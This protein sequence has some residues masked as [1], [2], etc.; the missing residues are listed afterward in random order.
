MVGADAAYPLM[1]G[2]ARLRLRNGVARGDRVS[3]A[4]ERYVSGAQ[5]G[6]VRPTAIGTFEIGLGFES[7]GRRRVDVGLGRYF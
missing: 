5:I 6:A 3:W 1:G 4:P 2:F 7:G